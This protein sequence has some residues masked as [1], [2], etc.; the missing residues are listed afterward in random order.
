[1]LTV[2]GAIDVLLGML[3]WGGQ[4]ITLASPIFAGRL[5]LTEIRE[6]VDPVFWADIRAEA[7]WD[8]VTL[9]SLPLAEILMLTG[10][11]W[12][13]AF[14]LLGGG[15]FVYFG[16]RG[17]MQRLELRRSGVSIGAPG[18]VRINLVML[19]IWGAAGAV[20]AVMAALELGG[21]G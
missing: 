1:M 5:G 7:L 12:W 11:T 20:C 10:S 9:W 14:G 13:P 18:A 8:S 19:A 21:G 15:T 2:L 4:M 17:I 3:A 16:G 6:E